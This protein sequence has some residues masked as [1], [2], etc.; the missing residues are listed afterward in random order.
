MNK[1]SNSAIGIINEHPLHIIERILHAN[2]FRRAAVLSVVIYAVNAFREAAKKVLAMLHIALG[3]V[4]DG[5]IH[6]L[7]VLLRIVLRIAFLF[8]F[9]KV[10]AK[11][12]ELL[13][14]AMHLIPTQLQVGGIA[15]NIEAQPLAVMADAA[16]HAIVEIL[17]MATNSELFFRKHSASF[18]VWLPSA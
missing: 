17:R 13:Y 5:C 4:F 12:Y 7:H 1:E 14:P 15:I 2:V 3:D 18:A 11:G 16:A 9:G 10:I 6:Q 8:L